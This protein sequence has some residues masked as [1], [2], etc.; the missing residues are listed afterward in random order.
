[1]KKK[2]TVDRIEE[3]RAILLDSEE[4]IYRCDSREELIEGAIYLCE[5]TDMGDVKVIEQLPV[6][7]EE[8]KNE[9]SNRL[10]GLFSRG[11]K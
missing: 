6:E 8:R 9:I 7:T 1:M 11:D 3:G 2:L 10:R 5:I 4:N